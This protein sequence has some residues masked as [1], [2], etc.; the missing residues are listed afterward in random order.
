MTWR[1]GRRVSVISTVIDVV[2]TAGGRGVV[3]DKLALNAV[4]RWQ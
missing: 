4:G 2:M 3:A 1:S